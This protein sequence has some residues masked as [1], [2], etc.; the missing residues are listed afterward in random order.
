MRVRRE[1]TQM[2]VDTSNLTGE[3]VNLLLGNFTSYFVP[4]GT[5]FVGVP[6]ST[7]ILSP[8]G[9]TYEKIFIL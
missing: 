5:R 7:D 2:G 9:Q 4:D 1:A 3:P 8:T 6:I